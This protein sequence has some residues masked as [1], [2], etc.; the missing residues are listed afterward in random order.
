MLQDWPV[1]LD[2]QLTLPD[3]FVSI[4]VER[5]EEKPEIAEK[6]DEGEPGDEPGDEVV[7]APPAPKE[8]EKPAPSKAE[9][10]SSS[11]D[12][13]ARA[14]ADRKKRLAAEVQNKTIL[15]Q[16]GA[17]SSDGSSGGLVDTL[18]GGAGKTSM[19]DAFS[20]SRGV[21]TGAAGAERSGLASSG[22]SGADGKGQTMGIGDLQGTSGAKTAS[23]G[24][25]TGQKEE[26]KVKARIKMGDGNDRLIGGKLDAK[27]LS[28]ALKRR[29]RNFQAC[30]E[31]VLKGNPKAGG[32][33]VVRFEISPVGSR[34]RVTDSKATQDTVGGGTGD[35]VAREIEKIAF[36]PPEGG[37]VVAD[38]TFVFEAGK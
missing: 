30:Y 1:P 31:R 25:S 7:E 38:K 4:T 16:L 29:E 8:P 5:E 3:R 2:T 17:L 10:P 13:R 12:E 11:A 6:T 14:E 21:T 20:G 15:G 33:V 36:P 18:A 9:G 35:C 22:S 24:V 34:G 37:K 28:D 32:R 23:Q 27:A 26:T 19:D